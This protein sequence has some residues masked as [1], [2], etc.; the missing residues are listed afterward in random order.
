[1]DD[2]VLAEGGAYHR[3]CFKCNHCKG[4]L[5]LIT[6]AAYQGKLFCKPHLKELFLRQ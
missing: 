4:Q 1:M 2:Q 6:M 5:T 3:A